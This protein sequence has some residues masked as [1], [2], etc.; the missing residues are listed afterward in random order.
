MGDKVDF[1]DPAAAPLGTD[2][3]AAGRPPDRARREAA[4]LTEAVQPSGRP[5]EESMGGRG[6]PAL[7]AVAVA[8][9]I[10]ALVIAAAIWW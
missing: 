4:L 5:E 8:F 7:W 9:I 1:P 2:D 10:A 3:E 6:R